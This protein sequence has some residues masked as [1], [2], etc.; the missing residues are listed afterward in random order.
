MSHFSTSFKYIRRSP[1]QALAAISSLAV[2]FFVTTFIAIILYASSQVLS[3]FETRPQIIAFIKTDAT[4][5]QIGELQKK[6]SADA[7]IKDLHYVSKEKALEIYKG[8]T[9]DNP[10]LGE[11]VS[12]ST[13]PASL[14]FSV[15][16]LNVT[17][18]VIN[19]VKA[20]QIVDSVGFTASVGSQ[21]SLKD[22]IDRLKQIGMYMRNGAAVATAILLINSFLVLMV[23]IGMRIIT[24]RGEI[25]TLNLIGAKPSFIR[26]P[27][28]LEA[29]NYAIYGTIIG[30]L[31]ASV[32]ILYTTP[33]VLAFFGSIPV[34]PKAP[35]AFFEL[36]LA[37]LG[38]ELVVS[39]LI[40]LLGSSVA[41]SRALSG[42][43]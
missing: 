21:S 17:E 36:L 19:E 38:G 5:Q 8:A 35:L 41:L 10:L 34:L 25:E 1:F 2:T 39:F 37:I 32:I 31:L 20:D 42:K 14:E 22:V 16:D 24:R 12:P 28:M 4:V 3:Y 26:T 7:R 43:K 33:T 30:W 29:A 15:T 13:L 23:V 9:S 6:L 40:A 27:I 18:K 11:L